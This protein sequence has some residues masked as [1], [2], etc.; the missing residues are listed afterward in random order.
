MLEPIAAG[1]AHALEPAS[2][3]AIVAGLI[4]GIV[5]GVMPGLTATLGLALLLP[6]T[7]WMNAETGLLAMGAVLSGGVFGGSITAILVKIPGTPASLATT[8]D[9]YPMARK[10][11]AGRALSAAAVA[12]VTGGVFSAIA[13]MFGAPLL[14]LVALKFGPPEVFSLA[15]MGMSIIISL[16][17]K[18]LL[19]GVIVGV[20]GLVLGAVGQDPMIGFPRFTFGDISLYGGVS[21][22]PVLVGL[23]SIPEVMAIIERQNARLGVQPIVGS[24]FTGFRDCLKYNVTVIRS[25]ILG[26]AMG[27]LPAAGPEIAALLGYQE[28]RRTSRNRERFGEGEVE[29]VIASE[30]GNNAA[31]G[32]DLIPTLTLGIPGSAAMPLFLAALLVHGLRPGPALFEGPQSGV[33]YTLIAGFLITQIIMLPLGLGAARLGMHLLR[34][35]MGLLGPMILMLAVLGSYAI[36]NDIGSVWLML[37]SGLAGYLLQKAGFPL[38]PIVLGLILGPLAEANLHRALAMN[39]GSPAIFVTRPLSLALLIMAA[40]SYFVPLFLER[41]WNAAQAKQEASP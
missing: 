15:I 19:K 7:F 3:L 12:S 41:R 10:G 40:V 9:G 16:S 38:A 27:I 5:V 31:T 35:P 33:V 36:D 39:Y 6:F 21:L 13:L 8:F 25:S 1:F 11:Q 29:G 34:I 17:A 23:Y 18:T 26:V 20:I 22:I 37:A 2:L 24:L 14:S 32:G 30:C 4:G 28:A